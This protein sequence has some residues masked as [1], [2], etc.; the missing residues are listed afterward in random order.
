MIN[1]A[2]KTIRGPK[3]TMKV[4][5][6]EIPTPSDTMA[7]KLIMGASA[8]IKKDTRLGLVLPCSVDTT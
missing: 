1:D 3:P 5:S 8:H 6:E 2:V 4:M 7:E